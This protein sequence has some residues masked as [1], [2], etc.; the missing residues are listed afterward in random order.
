MIINSISQISLSGLYRIRPENGSVF[1]ARQEYLSSI[2]LSQ[3]SAGTEIDEE[4]EEELLDAGLC[5]AVELKACDY[6]SRAEQSR[7][8]L[9]QKLVKKS[10]QKKYINMVLDYL[11]S[12]DYLNDLR[13]S[14]AWLNTRNINHYEGRTKLLA[15][16]RNRGI[17]EKTASKALDDFF[18]LNDEFE[19]CKKAYQKHKKNGIN[20]QYQQGPLVKRLRRHPLKVESW[21]RFPYG[22]PN[23]I[24]TTLQKHY[25]NMTFFKKY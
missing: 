1:Y 6:L 24:T 23:N 14:T 10:F 2:I 11:E 7:F 19:I 20:K 18:I 9:T 15:E 3:I 25:K 17:C 22:S 8:G 16:L 13:F 5:V 21:V 4:N 12:K